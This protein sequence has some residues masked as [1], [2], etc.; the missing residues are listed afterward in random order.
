MGRKIEIELPDPEPPTLDLSVNPEVA[1]LRERMAAAETRLENLPAENPAS[2]E[3]LRLATEA[4]AKAAQA[5][6]QIEQLAAQ[7][8]PDP[9]TEEEVEE[10]PPPSP[11]SP[12]AEP[13]GHPVSTGDQTHRA[14]FWDHLRRHF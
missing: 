2:A 4:H 1:A 11:L 3:A 10:L 7:A 6:K 13:S 9:E 12:P 5:L 8:E 14:T